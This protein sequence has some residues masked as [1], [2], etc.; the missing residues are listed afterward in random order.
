[1]QFKQN[2]MST[3]LNAFQKKKKSTIYT[4]KSSTVKKLRESFEKKNPF[5][6]LNY[7]QLLQA[8]ES[9]VWLSK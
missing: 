4:S 2:D 5:I 3:T 9:Y 6:T 1:M 7:K 8:I